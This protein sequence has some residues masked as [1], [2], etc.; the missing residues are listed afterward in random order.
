MRRRLI[1]AAV[2]ALQ[3]CDLDDAARAADPPAAPLDLSASEPVFV[4]DFDALDVSGFDC[5]TRWIAHTPYK[6][7]FGD[8]KFADPSR[9]FPFRIID[10]ELRIE[11]RKWYGQWESGLLSSQNECG[12][13]YVQQYGYFEARM[14]LPAGDGV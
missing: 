5:D 4:E 2:L 9:R 7:D 13:G 6:G 12:T 1:F 3:G 8:A 11:A 14:K 10:G